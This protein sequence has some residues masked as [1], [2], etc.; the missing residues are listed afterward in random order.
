MGLWARPREGPVIETCPACGYSLV[1]LPDDYV[2]PECGSD[3]ER[4]SIVVAQWRL[5]WKM[6]GLAT[7]VCIAFVTAVRW[8]S[9]GLWYSLP[10]FVLLL[11]GS[12]W[13][14]CTPRIIFVVSR[15]RVQILSDG[16]REREYSMALIGGAKWDRTTGEVEVVRSDGSVWFRIPPG[17]FWSHRRAKKLVSTITDYAE[18]GEPGLRRK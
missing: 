2:C 1:G 11:G 4:D 16:K 15:R 9:S 10:P 12:L 3:Y 14:L 7:T 5:G 6:I 18:R 17:S 13:R 8:G